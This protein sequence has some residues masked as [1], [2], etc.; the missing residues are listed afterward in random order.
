M[1]RFT[2]NMKKILFLVF[3]MMIC[4]WPINAQSSGSSLLW[5]ISGNGLSQP[6]YLFGSF[7]IMCKDDFNPSTLLLSLVKNSGQFYG[8][9]D[10][11]E[12]GLQQNI[13]SQLRMQ[14]MTLELLM[15]KDSFP[16]FNQRFLEI[17]QMPLLFFNQFKPIMGTSLLVSNS[18]H[19]T[20]KVQPETEF[21]KMA[22][23]NEIPVKGLEAIADQ[24]AVLNKE[25]LS[26]QIANLKKSIIQFDSLQLMMQ[27]MQEVYRLKDADS[28]YRF[29]KEADL[30][31]EFETALLVN[32]N[33][34]WI[35]LIQ[36]AIKSK[37]SFI[38]VGAGHLGGVEGV[39]SLLRKEGYLLTPM[40]Y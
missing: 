1:D 12:P 34:K 11:N 38:V 8:E 21:A 16:Y 7:H 20:E 4:V 19:C 39:V 9:L 3:W 24:I 33:H 10:L 40:D 13:T 22:R 27:K 35:P 18:I 29:M 25:P 32:R 15:G 6:S 26:V 23:D 2:N 17:T 36:E 14:D 31:G 5:K 28:L 30:D 37:N